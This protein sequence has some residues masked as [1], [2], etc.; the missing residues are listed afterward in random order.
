VGE[1]FKKNTRRSREED[2]IG[3]KG[4]KKNRRRGRHKREEI[5]KVV[6]GLKEGKAMGIDGIPNEVWKFGGERIID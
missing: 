2:G 6:R 1:L 4:G 3:R 5:E